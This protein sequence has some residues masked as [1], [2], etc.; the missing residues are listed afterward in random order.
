MTSFQIF[1]TIAAV[2]LGTVLT[3]FLPYICFPQGRKTPRYMPL[4]AKYGAIAP[5]HCR[6]TV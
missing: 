5:R 2:V 6:L 1:I 3:R 4:S